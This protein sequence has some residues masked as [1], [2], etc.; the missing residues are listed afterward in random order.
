MKKILVFGISMVLL[1]GWDAGAALMHPGFG[2]FGGSNEDGLLTVNVSPAGFRTAGAG[3]TLDFQFADPGV[4]ARVRY[5]TPTEKTIL[6]SEGGDGAPVRMRSTILYPGFSA[7]FGNRARIRVRGAK[8]KVEEGGEEAALNRW[9]LVT[10]AEGEAPPVALA[11]RSRFYPDTVEFTPEGDDGGTLELISG[12]PIGEVRFITPL[13]IDPFPADASGKKWDELRKIAGVWAAIGIPGLQMRLPRYQAEKSEVYIVE[14]FHT[15][16]GE[17]I[18]PISPPLVFAVERGYPAKVEGKVVR[19]EC[20]TKYGPF[21]FVFGSTLKYRLPMPPL[22][23]RAY[24]RGPDP[25]TRRTLLNRLV[26]IPAGDGA[27]GPADLAYRGIVSAQLAGPLLDEENRE[28]VAE[29]WDGLLDEALAV[30]DLVKPD[31]SQVW[32]VGSEPLSRVEYIAA[33][34]SGEATGETSMMNLDETALTVYGLVT[35]MRYEGLWKSALGR[36]GEVNS[37]ARSLDVVEDWAW[38][39]PASRVSGVDTGSAADLT[40]VY[41]G[42]AAFL[43]VSERAGGVTV[44]NQ[45]AASMARLAVAMVARLWYTEWAR[46]R[47]MIPRNAIVTGFAEMEPFVTALLDADVGDPREV[48]GLVSA[49][50]A[51]PEP[52]FLYAAFARD[53]FEAY[54]REFEAAWG[55]QALSPDVVLPHVYARA[56]LGDP[57]GGLWER[58]D[59]VL[60][61]G[62]PGEG[63]WMAP[64]VIAELL[65]RETPLILTRWEPA[66]Y[67][68]GSMTEDGTGVILNFDVRTPTVWWMEAAVRPPFVPKRVTV[69]GE[70]TGFEFAEGILRIAAAK[71]G[72]FEIRIDFGGE[73]DKQPD[74]RN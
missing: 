53:A 42:S 67:V 74:S 56:V 66:A 31:N 44:R 71:R 45:Y 57:V 17:S 39:A 48:T 54:E 65:S 29:A 68:D 28:A 60:G 26:S 63:T 30:P 5:V 21:A 58:I 25:A 70:I 23:W 73:D 24:V 8:V 14:A 35:R 46:K 19:T 27:S 3:A 34:K 11:F 15:D 38:M 40:S 20:V 22:G 10:A 36:R 6:L 52:A 62:A 37:L 59:G 33:R 43:Q 1:S 16:G 55:G 4:I 49:Y 32:R 9:I 7:E 72:P 51:L 18:A 47:G 50:G 64:N 13:G 2:R 69:D 41:A 61:T 12:V